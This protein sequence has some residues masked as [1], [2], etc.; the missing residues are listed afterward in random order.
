MASTRQK[1][2]SEDHVA[3]FKLLADES[4][5]RAITLLMRERSGMSVTDIAES[6]GM[7]HS[8]VSHLL[9]VL[10]DA[11]IVLYRKKGREI[12]YVV[13]NTKNAKFVA[14]LLKIS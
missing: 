13:A 11:S 14:R 12:R 3:V 5:Y 2:K 7:T 8:S 4:R 6:L 9:A 10:H 1:S